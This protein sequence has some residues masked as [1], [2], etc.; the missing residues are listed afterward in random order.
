MGRVSQP[1]LPMPTAITPSIRCFTGNN[2][3]GIDASDN[4]TT[5]TSS[6]TVT[7]VPVCCAP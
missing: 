6:A 3:T 1:V 7:T 5:N 4:P 2:M